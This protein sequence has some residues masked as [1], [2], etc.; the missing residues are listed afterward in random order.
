MFGDRAV[1]TGDFAVD[2]LKADKFEYFLFQCGTPLSVFLVK[3]ERG[4]GNDAVRTSLEICGNGW[5]TGLSLT[6]VF[7]QAVT[8]IAGVPHQHT[9]L[10]LARRTGEAE[11][12]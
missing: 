6:S 11:F 3:R 8:V 12:L 7:I 4:R 10:I 1:K 9:G 2:S 5:S